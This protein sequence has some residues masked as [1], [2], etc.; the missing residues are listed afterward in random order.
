MQPDANKTG[1]PLG[2][3]QT[4]RDA[5]GVPLPCK[6]ETAALLYFAPPRMPYESPKNGTR[7]QVYGASK[8]RAAESGDAAPATTQQLDAD[9]KRN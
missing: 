3:L 1:P 9:Y 7:A 2:V 5:P 4:I 6:S 8:P